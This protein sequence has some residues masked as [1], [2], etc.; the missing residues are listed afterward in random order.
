[1]CVVACAVLQR[2]DR[3]AE[4]PTCMNC[5]TYQSYISLARYRYVCCR[6]SRYNKPNTCRIEPASTHISW[7]K[8]ASMAGRCAK[9]RTSWHSILLAAPVLPINVVPA[10]SVPDATEIH[11]PRLAA[12]M[13]TTTT[14]EIS[15]NGFR[16]TT[17]TSAA[18]EPVLPGCRAAG[19]HLS[20]RFG[21]S[22]EDMDAGDRAGSP[23]RTFAQ[24]PWTIHMLAG[25]KM[26]TTDK[27]LA[28]R[29]LFPYWL[30]GWAI[31]C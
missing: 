15:V 13:V 1:M 21:Q 12:H 23:R 28:V 7:A 22:A 18:M 25:A 19:L 27:S 30:A 10:L 8:A 29:H 31:Y 16:S 14:D 2:H 11:G 4:Q 9:L 3:P 26:S 24:G 6:Y 17:K 5:L 20:P